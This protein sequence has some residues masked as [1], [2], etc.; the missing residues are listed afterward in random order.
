[1]YKL[2]KNSL[3]AFVLATGVALPTSMANA[4][5]LSI[6]QE[7][8]V[9]RTLTEANRQATVAASLELPADVAEGFW[10]IYR[11]YR[12]E[13]ARINDELQTLI[14]QY[15]EDYVDLPE[16][17]AYQ[18]AQQALKLQ[19]RRDKLKE[20]YL[21]RFTRT[22]SKLDAARVI[23]IENKLDAL[24]TALLSDQIPLILPR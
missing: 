12:N 20:K 16:D 15:A 3:P 9:A 14:F 10:P 18:L 24:A 17:E 4:D 19:V 1:M 2:L 5:E 23:Q 8:Q 11:E 22:L 7:I 13:V 21:K 6:E